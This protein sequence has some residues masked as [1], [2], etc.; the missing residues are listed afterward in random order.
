MLSIH[1]TVEVEEMIAAGRR[2]QIPKL[3]LRGRVVPREV[4]CGRRLLRTRRRRHT[5]LQPACH[6]RRRLQ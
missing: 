6:C 2:R 5:L 3:A 4:H 1:A